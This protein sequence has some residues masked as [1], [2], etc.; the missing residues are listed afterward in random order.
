MPTSHPARCLRAPYGRLVLSS[1]KLANKRIGG[2]KD[3]EELGVSVGGR[4][5]RAKQILLHSGATCLY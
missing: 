2:R 3:K 4:E 1:S 5:Q